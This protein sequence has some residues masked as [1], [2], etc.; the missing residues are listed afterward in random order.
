VPPGW[1]LWYAFTGSRARYYDYAINENDAIRKFGTS[2]GDYSTDVLKDR[3]VRFIKEQPATPD[4]FFMLI[5]TKAA[6]AQ[7]KCA[8]PAPAYADAFKEVGLQAASALNKKASRKPA[9]APTIHGQTKDQIE[10]CY[11][12]ELQS[13]QSVDDLVASVVNALQSAGKLDDTVIVYTSDNGFLFGQ[14]DL[15]GKSAAFEEA[16]RVPL[17]MRGPGIPENQTRTQL[18]NNLDVVATIVDRAGASPGVALD[19]RS[20]SPLFADNTA[21]WRSAIAFESP[22]SRF[23]GPSERYTGVRTATRKYI[24]FESGKEKLYD[25]AADPHELRNVA[26]K[27]AYAG[28][29]ASLRSLNDRLK[30]C[31]GE[32]CFVP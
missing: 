4:P 21:P 26:G 7:G 22:V 32:T 14:H 16:I 29:L 8:I 18:V 12:A 3:A 10:A 31:A 2:P 13:L 28:D 25:L 20:L 17:L 1:D 6:H 11:R 15:V 27:H 5:A 23:K 30:T 19:G 9:N 24:K